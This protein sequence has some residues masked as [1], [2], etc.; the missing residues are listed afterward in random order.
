VK[1]QEETMP[2]NWFE[3]KRS[4]D[5]CSHDYASSQ[6]W[7]GFFQQS[8]MAHLPMNITSLSRRGLL[9]TRAGGKLMLVSLATCHSLDWPDCVAD[10]AEI[11]WEACFLETLRLVPEVSLLGP[12]RNNFDDLSA[13]SGGATALILGS[14]VRGSR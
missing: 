4:L 12:C 6:N 5:A 1:Y 3:S 11:S 2:K 9:G 14:L 7:I 8:G 10:A 13:S